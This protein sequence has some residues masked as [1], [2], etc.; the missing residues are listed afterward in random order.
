M[1]EEELLLGSI[2]NTVR[3]YREGDIPAAT[4]EHVGRWAN[5][6][7]AE[8]RLPFLREFDHVLRSSF[9]PK[10]TFAGFLRGLV[11][12]AELTGGQ[13]LQ[14]WSNVS[15]LR[16]Q[17]N[18][19]SQREMV[20]LLSEAVFESLA[21][22]VQLNAPAAREY[23]YVDDIIFSGARIKSDVVRWIH[24]R[25]PQVAKLH[26]VVIAFYRLGQY[27]LSRDIA[28]AIRVSGKSIEVKYWRNVELENRRAYRGSAQVLWPAVVPSTPEVAAFVSRVDRYPIELRTPPGSVSPF[29]SEEGRQVLEQ[30][31][32]TA[33]ARIISRIENW[34][35]RMRPLGLSSFGAGFGATLVTYRNC[36]NNCPLAIWWGDGEASSGALN[37]YPLLPREGYSSARNVFSNIDE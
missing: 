16:I 11:Q 25:A 21:I 9:I 14:F 26:I 5:Q 7:S 12:N 2:A 37:W 28:E 35:S 17:Q 6:F 33:G 34:N 24:E 18:G 30:E 13:P 29:S 32:L 15:V 1:S 31:F 19:Q 4:P 23:V 3:S 22:H 10:E 20:S 27:Y 36:P 8:Y